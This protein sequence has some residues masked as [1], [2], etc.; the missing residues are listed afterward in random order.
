MNGVELKLVGEVSAV[1]AGENKWTNVSRI[2]SICNRSNTSRDSSLC[3]DC[4]THNSEE[5]VEMHT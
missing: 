1:L 5:T 4:D 2:S 3:A